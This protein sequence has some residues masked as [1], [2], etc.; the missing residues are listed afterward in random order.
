M[1]EKFHAL[2]DRLVRKME[3]SQTPVPGFIIGLSGTDSLV[4]FLIGYEACKIRG[5][6][7]RMMGVHYV[8]MRR[9]KPTWFEEGVIPWLRQRCPEATIL[10]AEPLGGNQDQQRWADLH[11][12]ALNDI[13]N[14]A[15]RSLAPGQNYW[16]MGSINATERLLGKY[17]MLATCVSLQPIQTLYKSAILKICE[18]LGVPQI[19]IDNARIPDCL[20]GRDELAANNIEL[21]DEILTF[22]VNPE[23]HDPDLLNQM[24][25]YIRDLKA[26]NDFKTRVPFLV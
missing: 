24:Y 25:Q 4:A 1:I 9:R 23:D 5:M 6:P 21:I 20:C 12:R 8:N 10:V 18:E 2:V 22:R 7:E 16:L 26:Q 17:A 13:D 15:I 3:L 14:G 11:L 19:A